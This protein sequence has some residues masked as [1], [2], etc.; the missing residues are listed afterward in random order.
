MGYKTRILQEDWN[1]F[2]E[3]A[4]TLI[5]DHPIATAGVGGAAAGLAYNALTGGAEDFHKERDEA[6]HQGMR[7]LVASKTGVDAEDFTNYAENVKG[8]SRYG[9]GLWQGIKNVLFDSGNR[10]YNEMLDAQAKD[11][12]FGGTDAKLLNNKWFWG[13]EHA[14]TMP[15][16]GLTWF[17]DDQNS[18]GRI[19]NNVDGYTLD[20]K[21]SP[22]ENY[23]KYL[24][25]KAGNLAHD[26][27]TF[28]QLIKNNE[29]LTNEYESRKS[30]L[31]H[32]TRDSYL[33][34]GATGAA[35]G[36]GGLFAAR[37]LKERQQNQ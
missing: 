3:R 29:E 24:E 25:S 18:I 37:K 21:L 5:K 22:E 15:L 6:L 2:K 27:Q 35:L 32:A 23:Q 10:H 34:R 13:R 8:S 16:P 30:D 4:K 7:N 20:N 1:G 36:A 11:S 17:T 19:D 12:R 33:H 14:S 26:P 9:G 28:N 31:E